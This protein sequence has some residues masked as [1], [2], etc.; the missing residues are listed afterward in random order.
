MAQLK[1][2]LLRD[3]EAK[4]DGRHFPSRSMLTLQRYRN[5]TRLTTTES[6]RYRYRH[7]HLMRNYTSKH[8]DG[9]VSIQGRCWRKK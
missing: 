9:Q 4:V 5:R 7:E 1:F 3:P 6:E 2:S 8:K